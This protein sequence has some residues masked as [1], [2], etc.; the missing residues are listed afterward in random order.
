VNRVG[1]RSGS[2]RDTPRLGGSKLRGSKASGSRRIR[3]ARTFLVAWRERK[4]VLINYRTQVSASAEPEAVRILHLLEDWAH[5]ADL[6]PLLPEYNPKSILAGIR[7]LLENTFLVTEGTPEANRDADLASVWSEWLPQASFH[8]ATKDVDYLQ[9]AQSARAFRRYLAESPQPP[10]LK[11]YSKA[12]QIRLPKEQAAEGEFARVLLARKTHRE[13]SR[14]HIPLST[15]SKLLYYTWGVTGTIDAAPFGK[16]FHKTS[17]SGG[18]RHPGEVYLLALRVG[19][20][21]QGLYHYDGLHH[22]LERLRSASVVKKTVEYAA[23]QKILRDASALFIM[24]AVFPRVLWKYR[25][26]R[27]YRVVMLDMGHLCQT[28]CLVATWLGLAPFC[29]A[30]FKD[31]LLEHDLGLDG[32]RESPLYLAAVGTPLAGKLLRN[33]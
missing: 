22:R 15:I 31:S 8:F 10:L 20:L 28:F 23:G 17:P 18:A 9:P 33:R 32:I 16:L 7:Q 25:F 12:A 2:D 4:L 6:F 29:T 21:A 30:A 26:A 11:T 14:K 3:R 13:Y 24:T 5:P 19:G 27:A 1:G